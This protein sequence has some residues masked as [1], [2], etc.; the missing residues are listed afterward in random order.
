M[1]T[2]QLEKETS[3][4]SEPCPLKVHSIFQLLQAE[5]YFTKEKLQGERFYR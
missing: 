4:F 3:C 2:A 5:V 1:W